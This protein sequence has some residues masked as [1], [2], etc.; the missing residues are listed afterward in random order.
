MLWKYLW[1]LQSLRMKEQHNHIVSV[2][3]CWRYLLFLQHLIINKHINIDLTM[4]NVLEVSVVP[5]QNQWNT[6][7]Y[8]SCVSGSVCFLQ[9]LRSNG[10]TGDIVRAQSPRGICSSSTSDSMKRVMMSLHVQCYGGMARIC[11]SG[12]R[13]SRSL[14]PLV[15]ENSENCLSISENHPLKQEYL[16]H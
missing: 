16:E 5:P 8:C 11:K 10:H 3:M 14:K 13:P 9:Q 15:F 1:F 2:P 12:L 4:L 7:W 6:A